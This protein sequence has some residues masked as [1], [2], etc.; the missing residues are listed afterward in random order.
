[1][2]RSLSTYTSASI[3]RLCVITFLFFSANSILN[4]IVP[5]RS[6][7]EGASNAEIGIMMGSYMMTSMLCRP[8][9]GSIVHRFGPLLVLRTLLIANVVILALYPI[10]GLEWYFAIRAMQGVTT[11][12]FS[13]ALQMGIVDT[14]PEKERSQGISLYLLAGMLP[15]LIGPLAALSI[16]NWGG[17]SAFTAAMIIIGFATIIV[18]YNAPLSSASNKPEGEKVQEPM[19]TQIRQLRTNRAFLVCGTAMLVASISFGAVI[20]FITLYSK[21]SGVGDAGI[22]LTLQAG[23]IV[24]SRYTLRKKIPSDGNWHARLVAGL[25]LCTGV[26][27]QLLALAAFNGALFMYAGAV[28]LG[29]GMALLYPILVTYLTFVLPVAS[30][31]MAIGLFIATSDFGVVLGSVVMGPVADLL[32]Y[33]AMYTVCACISLVAVVTVLASG[34][35]LSYLNARRRE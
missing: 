8:W 12:F 30:R 20:S 33:S 34:R 31:N 4:I 35:R 21:E 25:L 18:G 28:M 32:S 22:Y 27:V 7:T 11:A 14:L 17:M 24:L 29:L 10:S 23:V 16:W 19:L 26:G 3:I 5:L 13:L 2:N 9:A 6:E 1:M 15:T